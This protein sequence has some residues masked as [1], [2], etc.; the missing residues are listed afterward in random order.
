MILINSTHQ[1]TFTDYTDVKHI[2]LSS[3][4]HDEMFLPKGDL[5][6]A[7]EAELFARLF[8]GKQYNTTSICLLIDLRL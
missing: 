1:I 4:K 3:V 7:A 6:L 5:R 8:V 2:T